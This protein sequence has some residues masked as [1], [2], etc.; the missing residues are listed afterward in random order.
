MEFRVLG[1][2]EVA[3]A[4]GPRPVHGRKELAVLAYLLA[5]AGRTVPADE[6]VWAVWG[7]DAPPSAHKSLQVRL[8]RLRSDLGPEGPAIERVGAGYRLALDGGELDGHRFEGRVGEAARTAGI[9]AAELYGRALA[10]VRGRPY[11]DVADLD[12]MQAEIRRLG[13][14]RVSEIEGRARAL[15]ETGRPLDALPNRARSVESEPLNEG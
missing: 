2:L 1:T 5:Q 12:A 9:E 4:D 7:E 6:V 11:A 3:G 10:L 13:E 14:L 15:R 8:S